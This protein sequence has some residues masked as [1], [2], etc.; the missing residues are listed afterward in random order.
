MRRQCR[1]AGLAPLNSA[2]SMTLDGRGIRASKHRSIESPPGFDARSPA[3]TPEVNAKCGEAAGALS[4]AALTRWLAQSRE[5]RGVVM[6]PMNKESFRLAGYD[7]LSTSSPFSATSPTVRRALHPGRGWPDLGGGGHRAYRLSRT[8]SISYQAGKS[9][10]VTFDHLGACLEKSSASR[11]SRGLR[12]RRSIH[13]AGEGG[14]FGREEIDEI[15]PADSRCGA[16]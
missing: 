7:Y 16:R 6:A 12:W 8:S 4:G 15:A 3:R 13:M 5:L 9:P 11:P 1:R 14:L 2:P 10:G